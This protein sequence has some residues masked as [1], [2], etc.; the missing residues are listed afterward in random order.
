MFSRGGGHLGLEWFTIKYP[1]LLTSKGWSI[2]QLEAVNIVATIRLFA[3]RMNNQVVRVCCDNSAAISMLS[4]A[5]N[6]MEAHNT[7]RA[8]VKNKGATLVDITEDLLRV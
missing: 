4:S 1:D 3:H 5:H 6:S 2:S 7:M 8:L